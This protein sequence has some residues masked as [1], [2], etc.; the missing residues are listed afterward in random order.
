MA[1]LNVGL[2]GEDLHVVNMHD[3]TIKGKSEA[4][5][6]KDPRYAVVLDTEQNT[7]QNDDVKL[8]DS[9]AYSLGSERGS[10][11]EFPHRTLDNP[12]RHL[13][14]MVSE[15]NLSLSRGMLLMSR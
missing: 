7:I 5:H 2:E 6:K 8:V 1:G 10:G 15:F 4:V 13:T 14:H 9:P 11:S 3:N 12:L